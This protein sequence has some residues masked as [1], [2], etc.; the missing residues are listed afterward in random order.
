MMCI[1]QGKALCR[2]VFCTR[3]QAE[4]SDLAVLLGLGGV[5]IALVVGPLALVGRLL[6]VLP[7][8]ALV[9]LVNEG[10]LG[11]CDQ[12]DL[13]NQASLN[14]LLDVVDPREQVSGA[15]LNARNSDS[16]LCGKSRLGL[17]ARNGLVVCSGICQERSLL[18]G[19]LRTDSR[20]FGLLLLD[21]FILVFLSLHSLESGLVVDNVDLVLA[22]GRSD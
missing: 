19:L 14:L 21:G 20:A 3:K 11:L 1:D 18:V 4:S 17:N 8:F 7:D 6:E 5:G 9:H 13:L 22:V 2:L 10:G 16:L 15:V 12:D